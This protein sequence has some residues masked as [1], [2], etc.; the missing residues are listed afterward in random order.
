LIT[1]LLL[2]TYLNLSVSVMVGLPALAFA[3]LS[4]LALTAWHQQR[5][6]VW[7]TLSAI[8][9]SLSVLTKLFTG[10][11]APIFVVGILLDEIAR[12]SRPVRVWQVLKWPVIWAGV[13][14]GVTVAAVLVLV[15][16][17]NLDQLI[18]PH[19]TAGQ[20]NY[21]QALGGSYTLWTHL[22]KPGRCWC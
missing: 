15:G 4:L 10:F 20:S 12:A 22:V 17:G 19:L 7:L 6:P 3:M 11:L 1:I 8:A 2:P 5:Q 13:F 18:E 9:L 21:F 16:P 14:S